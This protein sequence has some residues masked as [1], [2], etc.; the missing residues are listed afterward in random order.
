[1]S[2]GHEFMREQLP[3]EVLSSALT[4]ADGL[5]LLTAISAG[6]FGNLALEILLVRQ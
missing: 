4:T 3:Q 5:L 6:S 2:Q 1:M